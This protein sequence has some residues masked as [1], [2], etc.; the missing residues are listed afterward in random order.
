MEKCFLDLKDSATKRSATKRDVK[1]LKEESSA[2]IREDGK[3][4]DNIGA[5]LATCIYPLN[6]NEHPK[7]IVNIHSGKLSA[8]N[9]NVDKCVELGRE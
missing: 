7:E 1:K 4:R 3:D 6:A 5:F 2:R 9:V 8:K